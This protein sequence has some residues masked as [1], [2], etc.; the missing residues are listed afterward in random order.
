MAAKETD[1][2]L[3]SRDYYPIVVSHVLRGTG[4]TECTTLL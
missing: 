3:I 1:S 4:D 2:P